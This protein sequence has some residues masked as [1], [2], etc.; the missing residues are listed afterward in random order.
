MKY[1]VI[2]G[3]YGYKYYGGSDTLHGARIMAGKHKE[4]WDNHRGWVTPQVYRIEDTVE[5]TTNNC[6]VYHNPGEVIRIP[7]DPWLDR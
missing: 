2:G 4:W 3:Q 1:V 5:F 6:S 7:K